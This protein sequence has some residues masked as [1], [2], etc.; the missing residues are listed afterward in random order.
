MAAKHAGIIEA[1]RDGTWLYNVAYLG[2]P[3]A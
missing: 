2:K 1:G 3:V